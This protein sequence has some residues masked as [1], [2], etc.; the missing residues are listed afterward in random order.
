MVPNNAWARPTP[1]RMKY[2][3]AAS[4]LAGVRYSET[5]STVVK[6]TKAVSATMKTLNESTKNC[7][8]IAV[9]GPSVTTRAVRKAEA[10][11]VPKLM[12]AFSSGANERQPNSASSRPPIKGIASIQKI[13]TS[14]FLEFFHVLQI[15]AVEGFPDLEEEDAQNDHADQHVERDA[16]LHHHRHAVGGAGGGEKQ[17]VFHRKKTDHLRHRLAARDHHHE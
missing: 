5:S 4:R 3:H 10:T 16:Q 2:F 17:A 12:A 7:S 9:I 1:H 6:A 11:N 13:S 15:Q 8:S 14:I